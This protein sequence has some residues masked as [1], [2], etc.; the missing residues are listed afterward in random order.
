M[1]HQQDA[2][3]K[4]LQNLRLALATFALHLD[5]F[6]MRIRAARSFAPH[7][8]TRPNDAAGTGTTNE[9]HQGAFGLGTQKIG[10]SRSRMPLVGK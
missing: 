2:R 8:A 4:E 3:A 1:N 6:E 9:I 10:R 7:K 5:A